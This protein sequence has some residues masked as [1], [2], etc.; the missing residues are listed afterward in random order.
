M[1]PLFKVEVESQANP[2]TMGEQSHKRK[3]LPEVAVLW[4][5]CSRLVV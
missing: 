3:K 2:E 5:Y 4:L 1:L